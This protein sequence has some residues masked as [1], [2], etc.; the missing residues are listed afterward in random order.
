[1]LANVGYLRYSSPLF[2]LSAEPQIQSNL[3]FLNAGPDQIPGGIAMVLG[4][5]RHQIVVVFN[6]SNQSQTISDP[7][8]QNLNLQ[9]HRDCKTQPT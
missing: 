8:L 9:L 5:G 4:S 7:S 2:R 6:G 1:L 3:H